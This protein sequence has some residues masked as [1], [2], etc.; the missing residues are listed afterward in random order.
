MILDHIVLAPT[1]H[2]KRLKA[3]VQEHKP[4]LDTVPATSSE[5]FWGGSA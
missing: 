4:E 3:N 5:S 2:A 1:L